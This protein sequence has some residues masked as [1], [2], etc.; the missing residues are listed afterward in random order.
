MILFV[1]FA[2]FGDN[3]SDENCKRLEKLL[4]VGST[5]T[6]RHVKKIVSDSS[7][8]EFIIQIPNILEAI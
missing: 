2:G 6:A 7:K 1:Y 5:F 4:G 8:D 3:I